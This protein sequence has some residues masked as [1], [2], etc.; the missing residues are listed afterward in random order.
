M[1]PNLLTGGEKRNFMFI[2]HHE[3]QASVHRW[4][5]DNCVN[6]QSWLT[7]SQSIN[8]QDTAVF[9]WTE[10]VRSWIAH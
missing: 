8:N 1:D 5:L 10:Y 2:R 3:N 7:Q 9:Y 4:Y 6:E